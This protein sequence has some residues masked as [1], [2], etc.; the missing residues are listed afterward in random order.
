[1]YSS[2]N[3]VNT[4]FSESGQNHDGELQ[5]SLWRKQ[6]RSPFRSQR[7]CF[8]EP[9]SSRKSWLAT[10]EKSCPQVQHKNPNVQIVTFKNLT[11]RW[12]IKPIVDKIWW[13]IIEFTCEINIVSYII[14]FSPFITCF[15]DDN[16][17]VRSLPFCQQN[18]V[19]YICILRCTSMLTR[20]PMQR[21]SQD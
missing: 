8:L 20:S 2:S 16:S 13:G 4:H 14:I 18:L 19:L 6:T 9:A 10:F 21:S 1:M 17:K 5:W 11:P 3:K 15:L 7:F 12:F